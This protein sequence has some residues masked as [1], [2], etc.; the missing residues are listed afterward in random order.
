[1]DNTTFKINRSDLIFLGLIFLVLI[2][3]FFMDI[4]TYKNKYNIL[5]DLLI[6]LAQSMICVY[7]LVYVIFSRFLFSRQYI[8]LM[9]WTILLF[10]V[11]GVLSNLVLHLVHQFKTPWYDPLAIYYALTN[12]AE[13]VG[14]ITAF[15]VGKKVYDKQAE[16]LK[17]ETKKKES[18]LKLLN[19][20]VDPHF[21]FN[22]L[23]AVDSLID[24]NPQKAKIYLKK[25]SQL[26][27]IIIQNKDLDLIPLQQEL[28]LA[29]NYIYL[30]EERY[31][32]IYS[33]SISTELLDESFLERKLIPP[34]SVQGLLEN[35]VKHNAASRDENIICNIYTDED[36]LII[37]NPIHPKSYK[38]E[39]NNTGLNNLKQ[40]IDYFSDKELII[41]E[42][43]VFRV[44]I[45][46]I[47]EQI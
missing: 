39:S 12:V 20:Q 3:F 1:M 23:N 2:A 47:Y 42:N 7:V 28:Q 21:L 38:S 26:Y 27:R 25:L 41:E 44:K 19:A 36:Y 29:Q 43:T 37:E 13:N 17:A 10:L 11:A 22:N 33:F 35:V 18:E 30:I 31:G 4:S 46:F 16:V 5:L 9:F 8:K 34:S 15:L 32:K 45:P 24:S 40:R 6:F 14:I